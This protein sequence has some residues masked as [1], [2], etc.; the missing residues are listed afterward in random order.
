M[1]EQGKRVGFREP[2]SSEEGSAELRLRPGIDSSRLVLKPQEFGA[3][4]T[5]LGL[6]ALRRDT[7]WLVLF[8]KEIRQAGSRRWES[9]LIYCC[10]QGTE[11]SLGSLGGKQAPQEGH[12]RLPPLV[13]L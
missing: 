10:D 11:P 12:I 9:I 6:R 13:T 3:E 7:D 5:E 2:R 4:P 8:L 1:S